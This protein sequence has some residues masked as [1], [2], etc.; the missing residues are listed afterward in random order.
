MYYPRL[1][2]VLG[3][4]LLL[5]SLFSQIVN[6]EDRRFNR[7]TSSWFGQLD[8]GGS[9]T[10]NS[11]KVLTLNGGLRL[12]RHLQK[13]DIL[14]LFDYRMV[15]AG[16]SNFLNAGFGHLRYGYQLSSKVSWE[17]F[18]QVQYDEKLR[19]S[20]RWLIGT[21]P[22]IRVLNSKNS[23]VFLGILYM[24]EYDE[25]SNANITFRDHRLS[26]YL[27]ISAAI[28]GDITLSNTTYYQPRLLAFDRPRIS[29]AST[30]SFQFSNRLSFTTKFNLTHDV[31][32][33]EVFSEV[34][35][36]AFNWL[37]G[38]RLKIN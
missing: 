8:L 25:L 35:R 4:V 22:R 37:N 11:N 15:Q 32:V 27:S 9:Y 34:P 14:L 30:L 21:G 26:S 12:D 36:T 16:G 23:K 13:S 3:L 7:D 1:L 5:N 10:R 18:T 2:G 28:S 29:S 6:I 24:Y 17:S 19:L 33:N 38:L 20:L 31:R